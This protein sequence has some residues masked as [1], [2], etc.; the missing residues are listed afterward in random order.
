[1]QGEQEQAP[2]PPPQAEAQRPAVAEATIVTKEATVVAINHETREVTLE[3][4]DG[5]SVE[6]IVS[7][8]VKN[9]PQVEVGDIVTAEYLEAV[10][11]EVLGPEGA[12]P[13]AEAA[14]ALAT[15]EPGARPAGVEITELTVVAVIEAIDREK[16]QVTLKGPEGNTKAVKVRNPANLDKVAVGDKVRITYTEAVAINVT[17]KPAN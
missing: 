4:A 2:T 1:M 8:D 17:E 12:E 9:L 11:V 16:E 3:R 15:A 5:T 6:L 10:M 14:T 7:E 13:G